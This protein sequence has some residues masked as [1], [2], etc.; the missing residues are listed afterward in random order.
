MVL[1]GGLNLK[2]VVDRVDELALRFEE[3]GSGLLRPL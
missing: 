3:P 2:Y 1:Q